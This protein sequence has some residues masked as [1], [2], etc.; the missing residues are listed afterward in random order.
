M[1]G[2]PPSFSAPFSDLISDVSTGGS[3]PLTPRGQSFL[4]FVFYTILIVGTFAWSGRGA[5][6]TVYDR[7]VIEWSGIVLPVGDLAKSERFYRQFLD[8]PPMAPA[9]HTFLKPEM[10]CLGLPGKK[11][12]CLTLKSSAGSGFSEA[13]VVVNVKSGFQNLYDLLK[14]RNESPANKEIGAVLSPVALDGDLE[15]FTAND[16]DGNRIVFR[17]TKWFKLPN[18]KP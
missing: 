4:I 14:S 5:D 8:L 16:P 13:E 12:L 7:V 1:S 10:S 11:P 3:A 6:L 17:R 18:R 9:N 2:L 15:Y